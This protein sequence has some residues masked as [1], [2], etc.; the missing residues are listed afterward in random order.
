MLVIREKRLV[1]NRGSSSDQ[2]VFS[3][4]VPWPL[5]HMDDEMMIVRCK[6][7]ESEGFFRIHFSETR[8]VTVS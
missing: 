7:T 1:C 6:M 2:F 3:E 8:V 4:L 5:G